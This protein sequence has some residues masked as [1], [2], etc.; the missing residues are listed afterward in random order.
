MNVVKSCKL[1]MEYVCK[2]INIEICMHNIWLY[3]NLVP[4]TELLT[5]TRQMYFDTIKQ[6]ILG[7]R[8]YIFIYI[9]K[10]MQLFI[11]MYLDTYLYLHIQLH[12]LTYVFKKIRCARMRNNLLRYAVPFRYMYI[13]MHLSP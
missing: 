4:L 12:K 11:C 8:D 9:C 10:Y 6:M 7:N 5:M 2:H 3:P 13:H 1:H